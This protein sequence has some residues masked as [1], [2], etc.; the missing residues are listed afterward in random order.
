MIATVAITNITAAC[1]AA[2]ATVSKGYG[3]YPNKFTV[4][5]V[6]GNIPP[7]GAVST[8][9]TPLTLVTGIATEFGLLL[10]PALVERQTN[11]VDYMWFIS[12]LDNQ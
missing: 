7:V 6:P 2:A 11:K 8:V 12:F 9:V 1:A 5:A 4:A 3:V 10:E